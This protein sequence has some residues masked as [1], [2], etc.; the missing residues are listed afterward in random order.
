MEVQYSARHLK[1]DELVVVGVSGGADSLCLLGILHS[2]GQQL[3]VAHFNHQLRPQAQAEAALVQQLAERMELPFTG[4]SGDVG[5]YSREHGL[6]LEESAR[7]LRYRFL[8]A[9]ARKRGAQAVA[10]GHTADDQVETILMH[11]LRGAALAGLKGMS[12]RT[13]LPEFDWQIP[14]VRPIL[15]LWRRETESYCRENGLQPVYDLSNADETY[16]RNRLRHSLIPELEKYNPQF[17]RVL[18]HTAEALAGDHEALKDS[19]AEAWAK[20]VIKE[21]K[22]HIV[23]HGTDLAAIPAGL[24]RNILRRA[25]ETLRPDL[26]NLDFDTLERASNFVTAHQGASGAHQTPRQVD[27]CGSLFLFREGGS[28]LLSAGISSLPAD[29][30]PLMHGIL[31]LEVNSKVRLNRNFSLLAFEADIGTARENASANADAFTA[32]LDADAAGSRLMVRTRRPGDAFSPLGM[33][34]RTVTLQDF[35][36]NARLPRRARAGWPLVFAGEQIA[37]V[38]GFRLAHPFRIRTET[39]RA[40]KLVVQPE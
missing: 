15:H 26:R 25:M 29:Q 1:P 33:D 11:F 27:L 3:V 6:S 5:G 17:K 7:L 20:V 40:L 9:E 2:A 30:W 12:G 35:F 10:T 31:E 21:G 39:K 32:W 13:L 34:G 37:W 19:V 8:F 14:L 24:R 4:G 38:P 23:F 28:I 16:F 36:V 22:D 18:L